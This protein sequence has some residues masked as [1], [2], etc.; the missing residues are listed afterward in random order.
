MNQLVGEL[1]GI[2]GRVAPGDTDQRQQ[3]GTHLPNALPA[4]LDR[5]A[6]HELGD[7]PHGD[8][9]SAKRPL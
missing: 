6:A 2:L 5:G 3:A 4:H 9:C 7:R 8:F 1:A